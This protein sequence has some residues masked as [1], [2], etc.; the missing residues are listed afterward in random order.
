MS[1]IS[2]F[3]GLENKHNVG[4]GKICFEKFCES[5]REHAVK[6]INFKKKKMK[7]LTNKQK[8]LYKNAKFAIFVKKSLKTNI[9]KIGVL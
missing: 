6:V 7:L 5:L 3:K 2:S 9:L 1:K 4:R 8:E